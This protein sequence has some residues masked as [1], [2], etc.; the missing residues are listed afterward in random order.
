M[1]TYRQIKSGVPQK[2]LM[3]WDHSYTPYIQQAFQLHTVPLLLHL[4]MTRQSYRQMLIISA[5]KNLQSSEYLTTVV[6]QM[7]GRGE[8]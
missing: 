6:P 4:Q 2:A 3:Y 5:S 8:Y 7:M 1:A